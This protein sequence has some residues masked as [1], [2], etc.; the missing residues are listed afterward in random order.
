[1][2]KIVNIQNMGAQ[3]LQQRKFL[4]RYG[5]EITNQPEFAANE[6]E[7]SVLWTLPESGLIKKGRL[8]REG[9]LEQGFDKDFKQRMQSY[10]TLF[11]LKEFYKAQEKVDNKE[12]TA[13]AVAIEDFASKEY[14]ARTAGFFSALMERGYAENP[15][16][17]TARLIRDYDDSSNNE[18]LSAVFSRHDFPT[19]L[20]EVPIIS[21]LIPTRKQHFL[22]QLVTNIT[23]DNLEFQVAEFSPIDGVREN[24]EEFEVPTEIGLGAYVFTP[25]SMTRAGW[26]MAVSEEIAFNDYTQPIEQQ[27]LD[28]IR[29]A[30]DEVLDKHMGDQL[31]QVGI[32]DQALGSWSAATG[33]VSDRK[34]QN[35]VNTVLGGIDEDKALATGFVS[36]RTA[37]LNYDSNTWVNG[38][39]TATALPV[40]AVTYDRRNNVQ[41]TKYFG[42]PWTIDNLYPN[43]T[44]FIALAQEAGIVGRGPTRTSSYLDVLRG[45]RGTVHKQFFVVKIFR[46]D[47]IKRGT[48]VAP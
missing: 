40:G 8:I 16:L 36:Q 45:I 39:G 33:G 14:Y 9:E 3:L 18:R 13:S 38:A 24:L 34:A 11:K 35:D 22:S 41:D 5:R 1:M 29:G 7:D 28:S 42:L 10:P 23:T 47:L 21:L 4:P 12:I 37:K 43:S 17:A 26:H 44:S 25:I 48:A 15:K 19:L 30:M 32:T 27:H 2:N 20:A 31:A 46:F 6:K